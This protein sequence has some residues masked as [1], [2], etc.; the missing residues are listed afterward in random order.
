MTEE[1]EI[2][3]AGFLGLQEMAAGDEEG[4]E[5]ELWQ[6]LHAMGY[7]KQ[8]KLSQVSNNTSSV[9]GRVRRCRDP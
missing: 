1:D 4:G 2:T 7:D 6:C 8:L 9:R 5:T 3:E